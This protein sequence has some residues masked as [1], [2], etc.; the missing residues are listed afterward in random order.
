MNEF[1]GMKIISDAS[2]IMNHSVPDPHSLENMTLDF[3]TRI[4]GKA[5]IPNLSFPSGRLW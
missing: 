4:I 2:C 3:S 5:V 1:L